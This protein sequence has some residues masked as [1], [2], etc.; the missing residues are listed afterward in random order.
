MP[1]DGLSVP[2]QIAIAGF[3]LLA[4]VY[5]FDKIV[6]PLLPEKFRPAAENEER[7]LHVRR[8]SDEDCDARRHDVHLAQLVN[9]ADRQTTIL[10]KLSERTLLT[11]KRVEDLDGKVTRFLERLHEGG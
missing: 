6:K 4:L 10:E 8:S 1:K 3:I 9:C 11:D 7:R 2:E 5:L